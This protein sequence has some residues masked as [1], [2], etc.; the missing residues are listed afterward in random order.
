MTQTWNQNIKRDRV[1]HRNR[2]GVMERQ[3][4]RSRH[5][6]TERERERRI[7]KTFCSFYNFVKHVITT[8]PLIC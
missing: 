7:A 8:H 3:T 4:E 2:D 5:I 1:S 6:Q